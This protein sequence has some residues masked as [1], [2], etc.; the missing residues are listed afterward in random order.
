MSNDI[1][2]DNDSAKS[3]LLLNIAIYYQK[4]EKENTFQGAMTYF[5]M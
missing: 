4:Y 3:M 1:N 2:N 5:N